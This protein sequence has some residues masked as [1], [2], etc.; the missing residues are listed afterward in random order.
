[1]FVGAEV[2]YFSG[3]VNVMGAIVTLPGAHAF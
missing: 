1:V 3:K 2:L